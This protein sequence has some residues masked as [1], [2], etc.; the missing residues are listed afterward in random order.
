M[1]FAD[2]PAPPVPAHQN[3]VEIGALWEHVAARP[4]ARVLEIG[5]LF[6]G[7]LW[8][9][10][11]LPAIEL[12][13]A[14]DLPSNSAH[15][16]RGVRDARALWAGWMADRIGFVDV[17]ADSHDPATVERVR[18]ELG[19]ELFDFVFI[20]GDH[21]YEGV[22]AD[23]LTWSPLVGPGGIVAFHDAWPNLDRHEPGIVRWVDEFRHQLPSVEWTDPDGV[24]ICAFRLPS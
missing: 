10:S 14:V 15:V 9:W 6:G 24:G 22:R 21:S 23:W 19:G 2:V 1:T 18:G 13:V 17:Q 4:H 3:L 20:D 12:L 16:A 5:S 11:Y 7:T 8:Y